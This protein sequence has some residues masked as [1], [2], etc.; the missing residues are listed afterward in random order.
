M[1]ARAGRAWRCGWRAHL[2]RLLLDDL[3]QLDA[4]RR[5]G[6]VLRRGALARLALHL[7]G[8]LARHPLR[9]VGALA[10]LALEARHTDLVLL[11]CRGALARPSGFE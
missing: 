9:L 4:G 3:V 8:A 5:R 2:R 7:V 10:L 11:L 6:G 1:S